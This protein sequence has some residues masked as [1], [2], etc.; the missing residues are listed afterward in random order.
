[1]NNIS[2]KKVITKQ[3]YKDLSSRYI[4][5]KFGRLS[6][7]L[8]FNDLTLIARLDFQSQHQEQIANIRVMQVHQ[9]SKYLTTD[10]IKNYSNIDPK[11]LTYE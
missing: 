2:P 5:N 8:F 11:S 10:L 3:R 6:I 4:N 9:N 7:D 1:M